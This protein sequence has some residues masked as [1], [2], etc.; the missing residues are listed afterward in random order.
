MTP[1][2]RAAEPED[3]RRSTRIK[4]NAQVS[5]QSSPDVNEPS[6]P[7][8][9]GLAN[10]RHFE[11]QYA[12]L[13]DDESDEDVQPTRTGIGL[14]PDK[15]LS[16]QFFAEDRN[17]FANASFPNT[18]GQLSHEE[19]MIAM[20]LQ[21]DDDAA[22]VQ[23]DE[24]ALFVQDDDDASVIQDDGDG[25]IQPLLSGIEFGSDMNLSGQAIP[26]AKPA[27]A[28]E[29]VGEAPG[30]GEDRTGIADTYAWF[31]IPQGGTYTSKGFF[32]G[33][34]LG[35]NGGPRCYVDN[36]TIIT[37]VGGGKNEYDK[38]VS[39]QT[40]DQTLEDSE[41]YSLFNSKANKVAIGVII[42]RD[43]QNLTPPR[44]FLHKFSIMAEYRIV[45]AWREKLNGC[46]SFRMR[47]E[48]VDLTVKPWFAL[49]SSPDPKLL[50]QRN[51][52]PNYQRCGACGVESFQVY[53][54]AWICLQHDCDKFW[55]LPDGSEPPVNM[56]FCK[57][58]LSWRQP[59]DPEIQMKY[60]LI[61]SWPY[62]L[63][64]SDHPL[65][66]HVKAN[67][68][69]G[70]VCK[71]CKRAVSRCYWDGW[72]CKST[73]TGEDYEGDCPGNFQFL[74]KMSELPLRA[75]ITEQ[76]LA[77]VRRP[78]LFQDYTPLR[79]IS[80][81][82]R[83]LRRPTWINDQACS[84]YRMVVYNLPGAGVVIRFVSNSEIN[85]QPNGPGELYKQ[86]Q[87]DSDRLNL[88][89]YPLDKAIA[90]GTLTSEFAA[91]FGMPYDFSVKVPSTP[92]R[93]APEPLRFI[94]GRLKWATEQVY[95]TYPNVGEL[96]YLPNEVLLLA[97][98]E[99]MAINYHDD[100]EETL[101]SNITSLSLG[102][103]GDFSLRIKDK[104]FRGFT[105]GKGGKKLVLHP[106]DDPVLEGCANYEWR[107]ELRD[108]YVN[109][110]M[111][112]DHYYETWLTKYQQSPIVATHKQVII[113]FELHHGDMMSMQGA[114]IQKYYDHGATLDTKEHGPK[115]R[116][117]I[118]ARHV[119]LTDENKDDWHMGLYDST[120]VPEYDGK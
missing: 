54:L 51:I 97:Y 40:K 17:P 3:L 110:E 86:L 10:D 65:A 53:A 45:E 109:G 20:L 47:L 79:K 119:L 66:Q 102:S 37:R 100:G 81:Y 56:E 95:A 29:L 70:I 11:E 101:G 67:W 49:K 6:L 30:W 60:S 77:P 83:H 13:A 59:F 108:R 76:E 57:Y 8:D 16:A 46:K 111:G 5:A 32:F 55:T 80:I 26:P 99:G 12:M 68:K 71:V 106:D 61:P 38:G 92:F 36:D 98:I 18:T 85:G 25:D 69:P 21:D 41:V 28:S 27:A 84:P 117:A 112:L 64:I 103:K 9:A 78:V 42:D 23:G 105:E 96:A 74:V 116:F 7:A 1:N 19:M 24:N 82:D 120:L 114:G 72:R 87:R 62:N 107:K 52:Q 90:K 93:D 44:T 88:Q 4:T 115:L 14:G 63:T 50:A 73:K 48:R 39:R 35:K 118:T 22:L 31:K 33:L 43:N 75:A 113:K 34:L 94:L 15:D 58:F 91:N 89:R 2:K 104:Y